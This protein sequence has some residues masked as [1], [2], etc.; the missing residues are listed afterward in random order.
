MLSDQY[1]STGNINA[2][3]IHP[4]DEKH[5]AAAVSGSNKVIHSQDGGDTWEI[6]NNDLP[7]F[8]ASAITFHGNNLVLGMNYG[9]FYN[10][11]SNRNSWSSISNNLP[12][13]RIT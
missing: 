3:A 2:I 8:S 11:S 12:N 10:Y 6:L 9:V 4:E 5:I 1:D 13:V 7:N